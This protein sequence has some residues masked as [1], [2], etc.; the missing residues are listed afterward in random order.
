MAVLIGS[1]RINEFGDIQGGQPGDQTGKECAIENWYLHKQG[2]VV[3][4]ARSAE[5]REKIAFCM[6]AICENDNIGYDQ[7]D[8]HSL[9][10]EAQP[11]GF[12]A[13]K[14]KVK[15]STDCGQ[16]IRVCVRY[17][18]VYCEDF[19]T[20]TEI[21][22]LSKTGEF[23]IIRDDKYCKSSDYLLKGDILVTPER[24]HTVA[25]LNDGA[26]TNTS[27][28]K[29]TGSVWFRSG[30]EKTYSVIDDLA[31]GCGEIV[32]VFE[33][34]NGFAYCKYEG[35][36]G[37]AS[38][39]YLIPLT[40]KFKLNAVV[41]LRSKPSVSSDKIVAIPK[42]EDIYVYDADEDWVKCQ[43]KGMEGYCSSL[44]ISMVTKL[45]ITT[46]KVHMRTGAGVLNSSITVIPNNT[47]VSST[48][49]TKDVLGT[50]WYEVNFLGRTGWCSGKYVKYVT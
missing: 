32:P 20:A 28:Y 29:A 12:D 2:W 38:L 47:I 1:A 5:V 36:N 50:T 16:A 48:G 24:G 43:Y 10:Y 35:K 37:Y 40:E 26:L 31:I 42:S 3:I 25:V 9:F 21:D 46:G 7:S 13:S 27:P 34:K 14:V 23:T 17:A 45:C 49:N 8:N 22:I 19:Y 33:E 15:C 44:Y 41:W 4:R 39:K 30:P 6:K 18:G 11:Y